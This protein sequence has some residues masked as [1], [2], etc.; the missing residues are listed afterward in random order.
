[1]ET[2]PLCASGELLALL[3]L[4][5]HHQEREG[6]SFMFP[7]LYMLLVENPF[8]WRCSSSARVLAR[9]ARSPGS[10]AQ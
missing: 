10:N 2:T 7:E 4:K 6:R 1:M 5:P 9:S 3:N 8:G